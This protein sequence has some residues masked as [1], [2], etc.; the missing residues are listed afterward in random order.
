MNIETKYFGRMTVDEEKVIRFEK[1]L[2][3]FQ[4]EKAF[5]LIDFPDNPV[6]QILQSITTALVAFVVA[7]PYHFNKEYSF[8][9]EEQVKEELS[10]AR[11]E[12]V[13]VLSILTLRDPFVDS[14]INLQAPLIINIDSLIGQQI[15]LADEYSSRTTMQAEKVKVD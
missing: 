9:L 5:V 8:D 2:P 7:S 4:D 13:K 3:G 12:Q 14:T 1:G 10:I 11:P 15:I 6:F